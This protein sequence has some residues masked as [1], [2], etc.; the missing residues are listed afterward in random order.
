MSKYDN[1]GKTELRAACKEAGISY[2]K[3][4]NDGMRAA[5]AAHDATQ[6]APQIPVEDSRKPAEVVP[7]AALETPELIA[8]SALTPA[9]APAEAPAPAATPAATG[10]TTGL[11]IEANREEKNGVKRP[12]AGGMCRAVWDACDA[13]GPSATAKDVKKLAETNGWNQNNASIEFYQWRK[14]NG[15]KGRQVA[16]APAQQPS[17]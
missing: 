7:P 3:L 8:N 11:K 15:I 9:A 13:I 10:K 12:S 4:N 5:L 6:A 1:L 17:A 14:F 16:Q 2:S